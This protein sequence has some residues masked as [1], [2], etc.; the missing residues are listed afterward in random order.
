VA[1]PG[2]LRAPR[3]A[4]TAAMIVPP[5][6]MEMN[7]RTKLIAAFLPDQKLNY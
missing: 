2:Q 6:V 5:R 1:G 4:L 3:P 7:E